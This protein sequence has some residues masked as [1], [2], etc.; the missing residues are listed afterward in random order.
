MSGTE[1]GK[2]IV[3]SSMFKTLESHSPLSKTPSTITPDQ[4]VREE[5]SKLFSFI[6]IIID[7]VGLHV[8]AE[9]LPYVYRLWS[10]FQYQDEDPQ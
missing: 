7:S 8:L 4:F 10:D 2:K 6:R 1:K 5:N 9:I 3:I